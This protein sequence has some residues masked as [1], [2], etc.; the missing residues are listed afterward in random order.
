MEKQLHQAM[1]TARGTFDKVT[2]RNYRADSGAAVV[3][4]AKTGRIV[5]M[6]SQPTY[7]PVVWSGGITKKELK[8]LYSEKSD[9]PLLSRASQGQYA[10]GSTWKP[11]MTVGA[12][13]NGFSESTQLNCSSGL[14]V[15][16]RLFKNY[17]SAAYGFISF[18]KAL[19]LS[20]DTFFYRVGLSFWQKYGSDPANVKA[21]DPLVTTAKN[22]GF[23]QETGGDVS[24]GAAAGSPTASGSLP[25]GR[26]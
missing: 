17:E 6:A 4:E 12:L 16:N 8:Q 18:A 1:M 13:N 10:P 2:G 26:R 23:G 20:C 14:Q 19:E 3:M 24:G 22:F 7:D 5:A 15:G 9:N 11:F 21:K 25:T